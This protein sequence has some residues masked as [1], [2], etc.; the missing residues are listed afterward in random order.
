MDPAVLVAGQRRVAGDQRRLG[1][2]RDAGQPEPRGLTSPSC[3]TP[4]PESVGSSSCRHRIRPASRWYCSALRRMP[5]RWT[6]LAV[7]GEAE[8]AGVGQLG[9]LGQRLAVEAAGDRGHEADGDAGLAAGRLAQASAA[10]A[11][12]RR[13]GRCWASRRPRRSRRRRRRGCRS[14]GPPCAPGRACAGARAGRR[15][16]GTGGGPRRRGPRRRPA[17]RASPGAPISAISPSRT[18]TSCGA[19]MPSRGS[20]TWAPRISRSAAGWTRWS[21]RLMR[22]PPP[23]IAAAVRRGAA[24]QQLVEHR[25]PDDDAGGDLLADH[26]LR[27]VD[28]LGGEL[29]P[30]VDRARVHEHLAGAEPAAVDLVLGGVLADARHE[31]VGHALLL[32]PQRV[33]DVGLARA[34]RACRRRR[35]RAPRCRAGSASAGR[36]A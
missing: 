31:G 7:V 15:S 27:R 29:D 19:S 5:A 36:R 21:R 22:A 8:R 18:S 14:R 23:C 10:P 25:H 13:P 20:S 4:R 24:R 17:R 32:H 28:H 33:D 34:R 30:A 6:G 3:M 35:S 26:G 2:A 1:D 12:S 16:P 11:R 9:H